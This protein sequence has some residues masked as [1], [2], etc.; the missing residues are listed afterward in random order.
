MSCRSRSCDTCV[1]AHARACACVCE[2]QVCVEPTPGPAP[3]A[4]LMTFD[5]SA[6]VTMNASDSDDDSYNERSAL[7]PSENPAVPS[8]RP[9]LTPPPKQ[10]PA[11]PRAPFISVSPP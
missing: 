9:D 11:H 4:H 6:A 8:Y 1:G 10:V 3:S 2:S 7:V 5:L